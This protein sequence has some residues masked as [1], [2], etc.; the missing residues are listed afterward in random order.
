MPEKQFLVSQMF[1][2]MASKLSPLPNEVVILDLGCGKGQIVQ[3][4]RREG[5]TAFGCDF[6]DVKGV[7]DFTS[8]I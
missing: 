7:S 3:E 1:L 6:I 4:L 8:D 2:Q 5:Y